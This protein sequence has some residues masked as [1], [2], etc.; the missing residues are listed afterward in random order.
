M[1]LCAQ[2]APDH[3]LAPLEFAMAVSLHHDAVTGTQKQLVAED[4][5]QWIHTAMVK[6]APKLLQGLQHL[7][8]PNAKVNKVLPSSSSCSGSIGGR[9]SSRTDSSTGSSTGGS[10]SSSTAGQVGLE[11]L[12][13][14][15]FRR[16]LAKEQQKGAPALDSA[17]S[18][19]ASSSDSSSIPDLRICMFQNVILCSSSV[20]LSR[21]S[22][23]LL[24]VYNPLA[25]QYRWGVRVPVSDGSYAVTGPDGDGV[26]AQLLPLSSLTKYAWPGLGIA[27]DE[28]HKPAA[29]LALL[30]SAPPL[31]HAVYTV[32]RMPGTAGTTGSTGTIAGSTGTTAGSTGSTAAA[33][34]EP[35]A[36]PGMLTLSTGKL[37]VAVGT[38]GIQSVDIGGPELNFTLSVVRYQREFKGK[39][40]FSG[41]YAFTLDG[42]PDTPKPDV[43]VVQG[44]VV[45]EVRQGFP[46]LGALT[47]RLWAGMSHLEVEWAVGA[48]PKELDW[49]V[50]L[51]YN[52]TIA[53]AGVWF[54]DANGREYQ[55]RKRNYRPAFVGSGV[56]SLGGNIYP[57]TTGCYLT[58]AGQSL[59]IA[60]DR[61][62]VCVPVIC[63]L[64]CSHVK[65]FVA[66]RERV[67][68]SCGHA[69]DCLCLSNIYNLAGT[70]TSSS[71]HRYT[72]RRMQLCHTA[73]L[74]C[75]A[76]LQCSLASTVCQQ[77]ALLCFAE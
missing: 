21:G 1:C 76:R 50:F 18:E 46:G 48:P 56:H 60:V 24:V 77:Q 59:N 52:T 51:R 67:L 2:I 73:C 58:D 75:S 20:L 23:F 64:A 44:P 13:G 45:H 54:T 33:V 15:L 9:T 72:A 37:A 28:Q 40:P 17:V 68:H 6:A 7:L 19:T 70:D 22:G 30:V 41:A 66:V 3:D 26:P 4:Y 62:Q 57:V 69:V 71:L 36:V 14:T 63:M 43:T 35:V 27:V 38:A 5:K 31:G 25:W 53:S 61:S 39:L 32:R 10:T 42:Q 12:I 74:C 16:Q 34:S 55:Q 8:Y 29:D 49:E 47:A 65:V 11:M